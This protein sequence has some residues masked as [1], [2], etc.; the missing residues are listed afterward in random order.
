VI[1]AI[2]FNVD[3]PGSIIGLNEVVVAYQLDVN[4]YMGRSRVQLLVRHLE[5]VK[6]F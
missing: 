1:D 6:Q 2:Y 4:T 3:N 5:E